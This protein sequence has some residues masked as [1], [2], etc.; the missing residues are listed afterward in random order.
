MKK[1]S[2]VY[3]AGLLDGDGCFSLSL[4]CRDFNRG[5]CITPQMRIGLKGND[6]KFLEDLQKEFGIGKIYYS[7]RDK[8]N[9]ICSWQTVN[10]KD[11]LTL[12]EMVFPYI[13]LKKQK[14]EKFIEI[15]KYY[16]KTSN[17]KGHSRVMAKGKRLRTREEI[18]KIVKLA[19]SLNYDRQT[20]RYREY[21]GWEYWKPI[22]ERLYP[23]S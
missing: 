18:E 9:A 19:I 23:E 10:T 21:H 7:N 22:I 2:K 12:A 5:I 4:T 16:Q 14:C 13:R 1:Q 6:G 17:P 11:A 3:L 8:E 15:V 20:K